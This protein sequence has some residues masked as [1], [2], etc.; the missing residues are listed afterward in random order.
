MRLNE[1]MTR[2]VET[3]G[4]DESAEAAYNRMRLHGIHHLV[5]QEDGRIVGIL[6]DRDIGGPRRTSELTGKLVRNVMSSTVVFA[7]PEM[8]LRE[9]ANLMRGRVVGCLPIVSGRKLVGIV[10][11]TDLLELI[12]RGSVRV[13]AGAEF[14]TSRKAGR[15]Q[16]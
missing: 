14:I 12:G 8:T 6:S 5:V 7:R 3:I 15:H 2:E 9:A 4:P 11:V 16:R 10:T 1:L 13:P